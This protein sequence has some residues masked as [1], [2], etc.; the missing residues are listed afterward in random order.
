MSE[1]EKLAYD[2][3]VRDTI[4]AV[5]LWC[6]DMETIHTNLSRNSAFSTSTNSS[7]IA[8]AEAVKMLALDL[9]AGRLHRDNDPRN[10]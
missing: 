7:D 4:E 8:K 9:K 2:K 3:G 6:A 1:A 5:L 10:K